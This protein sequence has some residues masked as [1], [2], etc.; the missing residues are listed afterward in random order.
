MRMVIDARGLSHPEHI[1]EFKRHLEGYCT[2]D[3]NV[4]V[5]MDN[6]KD[7]LKKLEIFIRSCR[8]KY[9]VVEENGYLRIK[10]EAPFCMCG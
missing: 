9:T 10:I 4:D 3:E 6:K 8:G 5:L 7:E 1:R 2:V